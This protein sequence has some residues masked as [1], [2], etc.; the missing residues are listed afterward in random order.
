MVKAAD[1]YKGM[2]NLKTALGREFRLLRKEN[3]L[4]ISELS[5]QT[6]LSETTLENLENSLDLDWVA[7]FHLAEFYGK[8]LLIR[9]EPAYFQLPES[10]DSV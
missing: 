8:R 3:N 1:A 5:K 2:Q 7:T 4:S 10:K 6:H 9:L